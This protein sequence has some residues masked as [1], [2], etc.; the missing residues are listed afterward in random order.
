MTLKKKD[1]F[2]NLK[3]KYFFFFNVY[4]EFQRAFIV[5]TV[6]CNKKKISYQIKERFQCGL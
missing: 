2:Q 1:F 5:K 3:K 6:V 4:N